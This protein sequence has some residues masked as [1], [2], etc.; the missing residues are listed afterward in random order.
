MLCAFS[1]VASANL[2]GDEPKYVTAPPAPKSQTD[3]EM[4]AKT[5][6]CQ[7]CHTQTDQ[8][9]MHTN[10]AVKLGCTDCHGGD[11]NVRLVPGV[12]RGTEEYMKHARARSR[13][14]EVSGGVEL[15]VQRQSSERTYT[16]LNR[17]SPEFIRFINLS[18]YRIVRESCG[19]CHMEIDRS[20]GAQ[21]AHDRR[22]VVGW[23]L[24]TTTASWTSNSTS[25][26]SPTTATA[27]A[28]C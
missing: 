13:A 25:W 11:A 24:R 20:V 23:R 4:R 22:D 27:R 19:A 6:G 7:T 28:C 17:E 3:E 5:E 1:G 9:T 16:L 12:Q 14:A 21:H 8:V 2:F 26:A 15:S 18:D 10:P